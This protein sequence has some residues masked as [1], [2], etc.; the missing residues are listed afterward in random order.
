[1]FYV[2]FNAPC[3]IA[4]QYCKDPSWTHP[5]VPHKLSDI[6][7]SDVESRK[8]GA[9]LFQVVTSR[10]QNDTELY[11]IVLFADSPWHSK[12]SINFASVDSNASYLHWTKFISRAFERVLGNTIVLLSA[13]WWFLRFLW[14]FDFQQSI[15]TA[16]VIIRSEPSSLCVYVI[17]DWRVWTLFEWF[18]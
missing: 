15:S 13:K 11:L 14:R 5:L 17:T 2:V 18:N 12:I 1:M 8:S 10:Q 9:D 6:F 4:I 7:S 16:F 3:H